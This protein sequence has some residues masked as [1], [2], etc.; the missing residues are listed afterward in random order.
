MISKKNYE[1]IQGAFWRNKT[2]PIKNGS[3]ANQFESIFILFPIGHNLNI[4]GVG[5]L[6]PI[7]NESY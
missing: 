7:A 2:D 1:V 5:E 4:V 6:K 3:Q